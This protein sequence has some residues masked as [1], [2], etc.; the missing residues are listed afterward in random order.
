MTAGQHLQQQSYRYGKSFTTS[1]LQALSQN[2]KYYVRANSLVFLLPPP[3]TEH[4]LPLPCQ[5]IFPITSDKSMKQG[6][7]YRCQIIPQIPNRINQLYMYKLYIY[8][9]VYG[10]NLYRCGLVYINTYAQLGYGAT[11]NLKVLHFINNSLQVQQMRHK[12]LSS[13]YRK[14][15]LI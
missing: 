10:C 9:S 14:T 4:V 12:E 13:T 11:I 6:H 5:R 1:P 3:P 2:G 8:I 7:S 15:T